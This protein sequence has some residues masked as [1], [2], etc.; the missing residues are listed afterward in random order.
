[1]KLRKKN[2]VMVHENIKASFYDLFATPIS[3]VNLINIDN[4][5]LISYALNQ[6]K[7]S[8]GRN[9]SNRGGWQSECLIID[10]LPEYFYPLIDIIKDLGYK[11]GEALELHPIKLLD[12]MWINV[13]NY[14]D[15]NTI[16]SHPGCILSGVYYAKVPENGGNL[17]FSNP[18]FDYMQCDWG[19]PPFENNK[20]NCMQFHYPSNTGDLVI[21]PSW[22][23]HDVLPN[24]NEKESRISISFNLR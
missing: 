24:K 6:K 20:F 4:E 3:S 23:K 9:K 2:S 11:F 18:A 13:N 10:S 17:V 19:E 1:M 22:L 12:N 14:K 7:I 5:S 15:Y 21:F 16:H 8:P